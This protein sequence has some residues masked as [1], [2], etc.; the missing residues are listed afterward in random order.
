MLLKS[1]GMSAL[2]FV[3][4]CVQCVP[5]LLS[6]SSDG[7]YSLFREWKSNHDSP[8]WN[9]VVMLGDRIRLYSTHL[10][11][12]PYFRNRPE[13]ISV[14]ATLYITC[15]CMPACTCSL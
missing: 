4:G 5:Y 10:Q 14:Y 11:L 1:N 6:L 15:P 7:F 2:I 3:N 12:I 9:L 8:G 13:F